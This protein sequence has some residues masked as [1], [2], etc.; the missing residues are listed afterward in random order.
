LTYQSSHA[1]E[2]PSAAKQALSAAPTVSVGF[3]EV[4]NIFLEFDTNTVLISRVTSSVLLGVMGPR[5]LTGDPP[6]V[7]GTHASNASTASDAQAGTQGNEN[8]DS[9]AS[10]SVHSGKP[11]HKRRSS[12]DLAPNS[13]PIVL[14]ALEH[15]SEA[16]TRYLR[17]VIGEMS[18]E[19]Q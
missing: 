14:E 9:E 4:Q 8:T 2:A 18:G 11:S 10:S 6:T 16:L 19:G 5:L 1:E 13:S 12:Q 7:N 15:K 3:G 17:E